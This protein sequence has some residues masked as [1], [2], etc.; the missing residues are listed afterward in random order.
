[1][2]IKIGVA[3]FISFIL[4]GIISNGIFIAGTANIRPHLGVYLVSKIKGF[5]DTVLSFIPLK[6]AIKTNKGIYAKS[7]ADAS[8]TIVKEAEV[9]WK[10]YEFDIRGRTIKIKIPA[11]EELPTKAMVEKLTL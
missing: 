10:I 1:M 3:I 9:A 4:S 8:Y 7:T 2:K 11:G 5:S 6:N